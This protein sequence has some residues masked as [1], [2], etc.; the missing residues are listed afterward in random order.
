[1][2]QNLKKE[3]T[4]LAGWLKI[5]Y[6][7]SMMEQTFMGK[8]W[9]GE[10]AYLAKDEL[11]IEAPKDFY[12]ASEVEKRWRSILS[13][14]EILIFETVFRKMM[15]KFGFKKDNNLNFLKI[16][17][18]YFNF[19]FIHQHQQKYY[20][21]RYL[22]ILRNLLRRFLIIIIGSNTKYFFNFK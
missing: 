20:F 17:K 8:K 22:V 18:G 5:N 7:D 13:K 11:I 6:S 19:Y 1:M 3:M 21:S 10:S 2:H 16:F 4:S 12:K 15:K 9:L 14:D